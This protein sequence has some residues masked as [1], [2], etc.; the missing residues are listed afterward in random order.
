MLKHDEIIIDARKGGVSGDAANDAAL[1]EVIY[2]QGWS[3]SPLYMTKREAK[4]V[5][6]V[7]E[8][9]RG[10]TTLRND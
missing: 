6:Y 7:G 8:V 1:M 4:D 3:K 2:E 9:F 5:S 10:N